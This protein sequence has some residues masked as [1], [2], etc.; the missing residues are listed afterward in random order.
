MAGVMA[1]RRESF[2]PISTIQS[3]KTL[4]KVSLLSGAAAK[5][6]LPIGKGL[7]A[8]KPIGSFSA[9]A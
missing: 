4:E 9:G 5:G 7:M 3:P 8:W 2:L 6:G 1:V